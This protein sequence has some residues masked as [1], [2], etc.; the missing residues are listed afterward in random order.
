MKAPDQTSLL[1]IDQDPPNQITTN[2]WE[3]LS[4]APLGPEAYL[5]EGES[6]QN[7][8]KEVDASEFEV[9]PP[10]V[11]TWYNIIIHT[12]IPASLRDPFS[13]TT[14]TVAFGWN[15]HT[16]PTLRTHMDQK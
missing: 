2:S 6:P 5:H 13:K 8:S 4:L 15:A 7:D 10:L 11:I 3:T 9:S 16:P 12:V 1:S 14:S